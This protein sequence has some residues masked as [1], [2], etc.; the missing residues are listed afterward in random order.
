MGQLRRYFVTGLATLLPIG[1]TAF[2]FWFLI[3]RLGSLTRPLLTHHAWLS[4]M[5]PWALTLIGFVLVLIV[6]LAIGALASGIGGRWLVGRFDRL[7]RK[8]PLVKG[9]YGSARE[10]TEAVFVKKSSLRKTV[11]AEYPRHGLLAVGF[12]T[13]DER[14]ELKDGRKAV[15]VYFPTTPN[16]TSGWL[17]LIPEED[18][19]ETGM[20]TD[21]GL[22]LVVSGGVVKPDR[23]DLGVRSA[24]VVDRD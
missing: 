4:R 21:E 5:P 11:I 13:T 16:P 17:A 19:T 2:V 15:F 18:I 12:L 6:I 24:K 8:V 14:I 1:F 7:M 20:S 10:L 23:F 22:R 9:I 3:S